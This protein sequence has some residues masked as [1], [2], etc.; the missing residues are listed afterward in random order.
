MI[1]ALVLFMFSR[2]RSVSSN[3]FI[4]RLHGLSAASLVAL[5]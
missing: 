1:Y 4:A 2:P 3:L 5:R